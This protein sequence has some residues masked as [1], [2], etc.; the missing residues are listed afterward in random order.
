M[1]VSV[2]MMVDY[3]KTSF[4]GARD[5][6]LTYL[7]GMIKIAQARWRG[8]IIRVG[9]HLNACIAYH[10]N[11]VWHG[12]ASGVVHGNQTETRIRDGVLHL[13]HISSRVLGNAEE[14]NA[15]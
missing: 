3:R 15:P 11:A 9:D 12:Y 13:S 1:P 10:V 4:K 2:L 14:D 6:K 7:V 5:H 8:S